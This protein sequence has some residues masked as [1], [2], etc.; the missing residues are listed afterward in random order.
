MKALILAAGLG[1]RL[2]PLTRTLP[3]CL[4][5]IHGRPLLDFWLEKLA[6]PRVDRIFI[7][8][9]HHADQVRDFVHG[10]PHANRVT[11][12]H[13]EELLGTGGTVKANLSFFKDGP[14]ILIHGDNLSSFDLEAFI[15]AH[16]ARPSHCVMTLMTFDTDCPESCGIV[17]L[18]LLGVV[19]A[20]HEK[21]ASPPGRLA[22]GAVYILEPEVLAFIKNMDA[23][24]IDFSTQVLP[25]FL[26]KMYTYY[27][28]GY[29]RDIGTPQGL[30][31]ARQEFGTTGEEDG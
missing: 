5:P 22:N 25:R 6:S 23:R 28:A 8:L 15:Q 9:H 13:E 21:T 2:M 1:T 27:N 16:Q 10:S 29:H 26:G 24:I 19:N 4:V 3:K 14:L 18:D 17:E 31:K 20:F 11:L 12:V 30:A 7:N